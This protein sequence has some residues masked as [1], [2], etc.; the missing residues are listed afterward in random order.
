MTQKQL[1]LFEPAISSA[2]VQELIEA[3]KELLANTRFGIYPHLKAQAKARLRK[4][5]KA[6]EQ[7]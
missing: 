3:A 5:L 4:A 2:P 6:V 1:A 7:I